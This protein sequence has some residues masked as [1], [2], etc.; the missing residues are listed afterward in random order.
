MESKTKKVGG[1]SLAGLAVIGGAVAR[2]VHDV[3]PGEVRIINEVVDETGLS[4]G[5]LRDLLESLNAKLEH[6]DVH[7]S[8]DDAKCASA[9]GR[10]NGATGR[11]QEAAVQDV[12][13]ECGSAAIGKMIDRLGD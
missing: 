9:I 2:Q 7:L 4:R 11:Q 10:Y 12:Q 6:S 13:Q 1:A 8:Y 3:K 5:G